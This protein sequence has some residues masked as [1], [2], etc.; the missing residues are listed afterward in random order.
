MGKGP[1]SGGPHTAGHRPHGRSGCRRSATLRRVNNG[2]WRCENRPFSRARSW[3]LRGPRSIGSRP[4]PL[5]Y[6]GLVRRRPAPNQP[7]IQVGSW[8]EVPPA[9]RCSV[10]PAA[11]KSRHRA[12]VAVRRGAFL[13]ERC[14]VNHTVRGPS[15]EY[16]SGQ[17]LPARCRHVKNLQSLPLRPLAPAPEPAQAK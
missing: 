7:R 12:W 1:V 15:K 14:S 11:A 9:H 10:N 5:P 2:S 8:L 4:S 16:D 3:W 6:P 17:T 13:C